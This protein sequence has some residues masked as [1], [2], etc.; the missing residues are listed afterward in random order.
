MGSLPAR[1]AG[2]DRDNHRLASRHFRRSP[3]RRF[4]CRLVRAADEPIPIAR[5]TSFHAAGALRGSTKGMTAEIQA[6]PHAPGRCVRL[7][8]LGLQRRASVKLRKALSAPVGAGA[9]RPSSFCWRSCIG[10]ADS[11][12]SGFLSARQ[13]KRRHASGIDRFSWQDHGRA[14]RAGTGRRIGEHHWRV[15]DLASKWARGIGPQFPSS[16]PPLPDAP[17][18]CPAITACPPSLTCTCCTTMVC[19]PPPRI[20][21]RANAPCW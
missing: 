4:R 13:A 10:R 8:R 9:F 20:L 16:P 7:P 5:A 3:A 12:R 15:E 2:L 1:H 11:A 6:Q 17:R 19:A 21:V 18:A 14:A